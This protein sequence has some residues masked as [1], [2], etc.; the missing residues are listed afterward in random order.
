MLLAFQVF[1]GLLTLCGLAFNAIALWSARRYLRSVRGKQGAEFAP[2]VSIL[3]PL[4]GADEHAYAALRSHCL[5]PYGTYEI[6]FGVND[7]NDAAIPIVRQLISEFP[8]TDM[9]LIFCKQVLGANRKVSNLIH[10][11]RESKHEFV[12]VNDG[13]IR[14][15]GNY[16]Q[17]VMSCFGK[18]ETGLVT[19]LYRGKAGGTLSSKL[20]AL[21]IAADFAPGV[22][23]ARSLDRGLQFA[24]G[25]TMA[26][27]RNALDAAGGF[28]EVVDYLA[29]DYQL[30]NRIAAAGFKVELAAE[31]VETSVPP[32][33]FRQF[34]QHQLRWARTMRISRPA[35]YRGLALTYALPWAILLVAVAPHDWWSWTLLGIS[36]AARTAVSIGFGS[37]LLND[38]RVI[39]QLW[40]LPIRDCLALAIWFWSYAADTVTWRGEKFRLDQGKMRPVAATKSQVIESRSD[41][42]H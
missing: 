41:I 15:E 27:R 5:Q 19:C 35:G 30:G 14:V 21:G 8:R 36:C 40:L 12:L 1:L 23:T 9:R 3:K 25:S 7:E 4:K 6:L 34:W 20:E 29:D 10:L 39:S 33:N 31:V 26:L 42:S 17:N 16:L 2:P 22:L 24:L 32:Y 28:E 38:K 13:D 18:P 37:K 11:L